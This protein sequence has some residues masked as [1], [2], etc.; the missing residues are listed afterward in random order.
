M[1]RTTR[2]W[3]FVFVAVPVPVAAVV[4]GSRRAHWTQTS[5]KSC[6]DRE[7]NVPLG[8]CCFC[9]WFCLLFFLAGGAMY[10]A[11]AAAN[12]ALLPLSAGVFVVAGVFVSSFRL[13]FRLRSCSFV[14]A[15]GDSKSFEAFRTDT[16]CKSSPSKSCGRR[17]FQLA[18]ASSVSYP[19]SLLLP[20]RMTLSSGDTIVTMLPLASVS[21]S[22]VVDVDVDVGIDDRHL[23]SVLAI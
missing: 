20:P 10:S 3:W 15:A 11:E 19:S 18:S 7:S 22:V 14:V 8:C 13:S 2:S 6:R 9:F 12:L 17:D 1:T 23:L 21:V 4:V 16:A 5:A